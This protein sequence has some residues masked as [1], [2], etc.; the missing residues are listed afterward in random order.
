ML[1][2][3][4]THVLVSDRVVRFV[5]SEQINSTSAWETSNDSG[6]DISSALRSPNT[7]FRI[8]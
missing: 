6:I 2:S 1:N 7:N 8:Q 5:M 3:P 4:I